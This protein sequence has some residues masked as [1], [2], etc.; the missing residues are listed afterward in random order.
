MNNKAI[1][2]FD[3]GVGG[4]TVTKA[5]SE[6]LPNENLVYFGDT[7]HLPYGD[8]SAEAIQNYS[9]GIAE[10]LIESHQVKAILVACNSASAVAFKV[11]QERFGDIVPIFNVIDPVARYIGLES[12]FPK[13]GVIGTRATI[14]SKTYTNKIQ[15]L[16]AEVE[17]SSL[18]TPLLVPIIEEGLSNTSI[19]SETLRHYLSN[20]VLK[21]VE[22][23]ILGC[24]HY[25]HI[26]EEIEQLKRNT[27][28]LIDSP[29]IVSRNVKDVLG[30]MNLLNDSADSGE[31][32][33][34]VSDYTDVFE[35]IAQLMFGENIHLQEQNIWK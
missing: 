19:S 12:N 29:E 25:P 21:S 23:L 4:L 14:S 9:L 11:L 24:T 34:Y 30:S 28:A 35:H 22:A 31:Y 16:N 17:V 7:A 8:K 1:G 27:I 18:P 15:E 3:S 26:Q 33:F 32:S 2:V 5:L 6:L 13:V 10:Y 20:D